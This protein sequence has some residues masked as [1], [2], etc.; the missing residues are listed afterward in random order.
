MSDFS[1]HVSYCAV[2]HFSEDLSLELISVTS[3]LHLFSNSQ[4]LLGK[5]GFYD[6]WALLKTTHISF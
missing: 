5:T 3:S 4:T 2:S 6:L 1:F